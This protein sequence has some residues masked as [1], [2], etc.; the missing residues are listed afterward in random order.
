MVTPI[1]KDMF[2]SRVSHICKMY[3]L[4]T[5]ED[6]ADAGRKFFRRTPNCGMMSLGEIEV[7]LFHHNL[8]FADATGE[9][10]I[11]KTPIE[12]QRLENIRDK[13]AMC[14]LQGLLSNPKLKQQIIEKG[15]ARGGWIEESAWSWANSMMEIRKRGKDAKD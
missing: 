14:A 6:V 10:K 2:S 15:G 1:T 4:K 9:S 12:N 11:Q 13:F 8:K 5:L 7:V 3:N